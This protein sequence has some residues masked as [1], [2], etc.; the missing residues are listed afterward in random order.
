[1]WN[2]RSRPEE[3]IPSLPTATHTLL[4]PG[5]PKLPHQTAR[6][7]SSSF[8]VGNQ[9]VDRTT[10]ATVVEH[11]GFHVTGKQIAERLFVLCFRVP[12]LRLDSEAFPAQ[13]WSLFKPCSWPCAPYAAPMPITFLERIP[14]SLLPV[15]TCT[16]RPEV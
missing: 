12:F 5:S 4:F 13:C 15:R 9:Q 11:D 2:V 10:G 1:M 16:V 8:A 6:H 3:R 7:L 14:R